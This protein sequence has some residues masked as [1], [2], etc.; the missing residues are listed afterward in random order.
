MLT[1]GP[2]GLGRETG[3]ALGV[4]SGEMGETEDSLCQGAALEPYDWGVCD[5]ALL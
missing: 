2:Q 1:P 4:H 3:I 5:E